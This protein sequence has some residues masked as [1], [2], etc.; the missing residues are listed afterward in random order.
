MPGLGQS[1]G[2]LDLAEAL[3]DAL[4]QALAGGVARMPGGAPVDAGRAPLAEPAEAA[5]D[6]DMRGDGSLAHPIDEVGHVIGLV[7]AE[8]DTP[9]LAPGAPAW[10]T[11]PP[12]RRQSW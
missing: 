11:R 12:A 10:P 9:P 6:G 2:G 1:A 8:R 7:G 4:A 5:V 3:L